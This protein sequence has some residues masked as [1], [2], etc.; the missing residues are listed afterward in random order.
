MKVLVLGATG[1]VGAAIVDHLLAAGD[2]PVA[3]TRS[4]AATL[5][6]GVEV[7]R[8]DLTDPATLTGLVTDDIDAVVQAATPTGDWAVDLAAIEALVAPLRGTD[9]AFVYTSGVW[10]L[11]ATEQGDEQSPTRPITI[12]AGRENVERAVLD[13]AADGVRAVVI[14]PGIVHGA[15]GGI[16]GIL[17]AWAA[18]QG[19]GRYVGAAGTR[20]PMVHRDDLA[21]LDR[22][23]IRQ[24][25]AGVILHGVTEPAV[26]VE[27]LARAADLANGGAGVA[28]TWPVTEAAAVVGEPFAEAL[29][30]DQVVTAAA[31]TELGWRPT[32]PDSVTD[33][34]A[35]PSAKQSADDTD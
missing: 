5:P 11:G 23:A 16:P 15:G 8:G 30:L 27:E 25:P 28:E 4:E 31:S 10:V 33:V 3:V 19:T 34:R 22:T 7:R 18:E 32:A 20:W 14:R 12:V 2:V 35:Y 13:T 6:A 26:A 17:V 29:A 1:Y 9:R 21:A 24:A